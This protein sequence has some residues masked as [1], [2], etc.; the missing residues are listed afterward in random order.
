MPFSLKLAVL[1]ILCTIGACAIQGKKPEVSIGKLTQ[2]T[3]GGQTTMGPRDWC[4]LNCSSVVDFDIDFGSGNTG[5]VE[6]VTDDAYDQFLKNSIT[7]PT[8]TGSVIGKR[9]AT[10]TALKLA[11]PIVIIQCA[12]AI[13]RY[14]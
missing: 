3:S 8:Q 12:N 11:G 13:T 6:I 4:V 5:N 7:F 2:C 9:T 10:A 14:V 1:A